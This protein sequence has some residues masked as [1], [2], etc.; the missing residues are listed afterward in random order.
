MFRSIQTVA[1]SAGRAD[2]W[3]IQVVDDV[4]LCSSDMI[5]GQQYV[6]NKYFDGDLLDK[7]VAPVDGL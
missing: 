5:C 7:S 1:S 4:S 6:F 3:F 2:G